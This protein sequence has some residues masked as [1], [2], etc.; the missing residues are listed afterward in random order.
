M[1]YEIG[2]DE[3][4]LYEGK[5]G[6]QQKTLLLTDFILTSKKMIFENT[7]GVFKK[8]K[9]LVDQV[10]LDTIKIYNDEVQVKQKMDRIQIQT[11]D[12]NLTIYFSGLIEAN[13]ALT[14]IIDA[15]TGTTVLKRGSNMV[16]GTLDLIDETLGLDT[17]GM[18][19]NV[20]ENGVKGVLFNGIKRK[21]K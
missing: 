5:V 12:K 16:K 18:V 9:V 1:N 2:A 7:K 19:K 11:I 6:Y 17:R 10:N 14:K 3:V 8:E 4:I 15:T 20:V 21:N 13:K